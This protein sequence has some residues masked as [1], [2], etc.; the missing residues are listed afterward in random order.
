[1]PPGYRP[2][3]SLR[4]D[5]T[6]LR[7]VGALQEDDLDFSNASWVNPGTHH[8]RGGSPP[9]ENDLRDF[10]VTAGKVD[11]QPLP[12]VVGQF[13]VITAVGFGQD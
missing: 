10:R 7:A 12:D 11:R 5:R 2:R 8:T 1:M 9:S 6:T 3:S 4:Q 13:L